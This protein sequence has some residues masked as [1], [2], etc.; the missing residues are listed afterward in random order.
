MYSNNKLT[1]LL[2]YIE[3]GAVTLISDRVSQ[4]NVQTRF[5]VDNNTWP[6]EQLASFIPLLLVCN[7]GHRTPEEVA[8]V[9]GL[10]YS[11]DIDKVAPITGEEPAVKRTKLD[12][13]ENV[14]NIS[15]TK[16]ATKKIEEILALLEKSTEPTF[17]LVEGGPGIGKSVWLKEIAYQWGKKQLLQKFEL[18]LLVCLRDPSLQQTKSVGD[19]LQLLYKGDENATEVVSVCSECLSKNGG[20]NI[21]L[22]L[23]GYDEYPKDLQESSLITDI[24]QRQVLPL[25]G[26]VVSSRPHASEHLRT[27]ANMRVDILGFAETERDSYIKRL[28]PD[29]PHKIQE[30]MQY[31]ILRPSIDSICFIPFSMVILLYLFKLGIPLPNKSAEL[32]Q[33]FICSTICRHLHRFDSPLTYNITDLTNL[34]EPYNTIIKQ[35]SKLSLE[36]LNDRKLIF[37]LDEII[38]ACPDIA[39]IPGA[40]NGFGLLQAVQHFGL[41]SKTMTLNF[42]HFTIQEFLAAYYISNLPPDEELEVIKKNFWNNSHFNVFSIYLSLTRGQR[43]PFKQFLS[44]GNGAVV[45]SHDFLKDQ[46]KSLH[47]YLLS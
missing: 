18:V 5:M 27:K 37:S 1:T 15:S 17:I 25:C 26:L 45:I 38:A 39:T 2:L 31:L 14:Q 12:R 44:G 30:L 11:G 7:Q 8:S 24:L 20:K 43:L 40:I 32:Y 33:Y 9:A 22:L 10:M 28:L 47:L 42:M 23:D 36:A 21:T 13:A 4:I 34:P 16:K 35:L 46:L 29:Q 19:L 41:Y 3:A 6:P